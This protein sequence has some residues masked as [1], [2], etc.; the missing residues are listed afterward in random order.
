M[1]TTLPYNVR[2]S[3]LDGFGVP[4]YIQMSPQ[5][6]VVS[7][8]QFH[9]PP[10]SPS[11]GPLEDGLLGAHQ[12]TFWPSE[13]QLALAQTSWLLF[14]TEVRSSCPEAL[15]TQPSMLQVSCS[16]HSFRLQDVTVAPCNQPRVLYHPLEF[17]N[18][19]TTLL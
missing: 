2:N 3:V 5:L 13:F 8:V 18:C 9:P 12:W 15:C 14:S 4:L 6:K 7:F 1:K 17:P 10:S 19:L 11:F 16:F